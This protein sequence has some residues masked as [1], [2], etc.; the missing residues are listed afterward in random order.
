MQVLADYQ[1]REA[2]GQLG[3]VFVFARDGVLAGLELWSID[4]K[5]ATD[6]LPPVDALEPIG[7]EPPS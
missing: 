6:Q 2:V 4:G 7:G 3:G 5:A 1:W